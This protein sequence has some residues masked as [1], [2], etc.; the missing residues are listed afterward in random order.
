MS[1]CPEVLI[2]SATGVPTLQ[3]TLHRRRPRLGPRAVSLA[4]FVMKGTKAAPVVR[5][6]KKFKVFKSQQEQHGNGNAISSPWPKPQIAGLQ[7]AEPA[8]FLHM[9]ARSRQVPRPSP[10]ACGANSPRWRR[11]QR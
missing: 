10:W 1:R 2:T 3:R 9:Y 5:T 7:D 8:P 6:E 4:L 11:R